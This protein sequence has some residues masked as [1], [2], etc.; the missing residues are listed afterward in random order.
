MRRLEDIAMPESINWDAI[1]IIEG[2]DCVEFVRKTRHKHYKE[3]HGFPNDEEN[4]YLDNAA[5]DFDR[6][7]EVWEKGKS[8][9]LT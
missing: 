8:L 6:Q 4:K 2:F 7:W 1:P 5:R 9:I 3:R